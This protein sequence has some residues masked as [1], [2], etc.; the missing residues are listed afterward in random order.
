MLRTIKQKRRKVEKQI[1]QFIEQHPAL[2]QTF[3]LLI[4]IPGVGPVITWYS[5]IHTH[6][7]KKISTAR[8]FACYCCVAPFKRQS[9]TSIQGATKVSKFGNRLLK[10]I[11]HLGAMNSRTSDPEMRA[12]YDRKMEQKTNHNLVM[13]ALV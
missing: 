8:K 6:N 2:S 11:L 12:Y 4:S 1:Q 7:F 3:E 10:S 5:I 13:N 9:G